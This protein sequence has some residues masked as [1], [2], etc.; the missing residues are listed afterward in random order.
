MLVEFVDAVQAQIRER[1]A[2][3]P[4]EDNIIDGSKLARKVCDQDSVKAQYNEHIYYACKVLV[5][6]SV[7]SASYI[8]LIVLRKDHR[9]EFLPQFTGQV[10]PHF[11]RLQGEIFQKKKTVG[12]ACCDA[13]VW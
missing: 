5:Q 11:Y 7:R 9:E 12:L 2:S 13:K 3:G 6:V 10:D 1:E 4:Q 8:A